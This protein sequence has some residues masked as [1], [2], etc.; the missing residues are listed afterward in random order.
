MSVSK[1]MRVAR[2][3]VVMETRIILDDITFRRRNR[4]PAALF[5]NLREH[6]Q[7]RQKEHTGDQHRQP[8][9]VVGDPRDRAIGERAQDGGESGGD[10]PQTKKLGGAIRW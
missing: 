4:E 5:V 7:R 9:I 3:K 2:E 1:K 8:M 10:T 6:H